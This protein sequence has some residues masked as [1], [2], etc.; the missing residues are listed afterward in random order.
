[1]K[2]F[3]IGLLAAGLL[4]GHAVF[5]AEEAPAAKD[6]SPSAT[7]VKAEATAPQLAI[8]SDEEK[9]NYSLGYELGQDL[10]RQELKLLPEA[11]IRGA[12][13]A[14]SGNRALVKPTQRNKALK[15]IREARAAENLAKSQAFLETVAKKEDMKTLPSGLMYREIKAGEGAT[16]M[17]QDAVVVNYRGY[18]ADGT[19]FDSSYERGKPTTLQVRKVIKGWREALLLMKEGAQWELFIPPDLAYGKRGRQKSIPPNSALV[20][21]VE[22]IAVQKQV[23]VPR[24]PAPP[25]P[26]TPPMPPAVTQ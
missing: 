11:L 25:M 19:E 7:E 18:L 2:H 22:L 17:V 15:D 8:E 13:D 6:E 23:P 12:E 24:R 4:Q 3:V 5:A 26:P 21:E 10:K 14:L 1:M 20:F 9:V 16:P